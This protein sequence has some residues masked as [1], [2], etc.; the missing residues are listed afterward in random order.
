METEDLS[1]NSFKFLF[2]FFHF[3]LEFKRG[4]DGEYMKLWKII[5]QI[6]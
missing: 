6:P 2:E 1:F 3:L 4:K 5:F